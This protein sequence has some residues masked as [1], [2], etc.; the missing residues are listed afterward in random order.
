MV[1]DHV[2]APAACP[3]CVYAGT[4]RVVLLRLGGLTVLIRNDGRATVLAL[5][6]AIVLQMSVGGIHTIVNLF[7]AMDCVWCKC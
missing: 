4:L 6:N 7:A 3:Y 2:G 5:Q 1:V